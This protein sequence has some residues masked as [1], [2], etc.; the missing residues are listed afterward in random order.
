MSDSLRTSPECQNQ[1]VGLTRSLAWVALGANGLAAACYG[2]ERAFLALGMHVEWAAFL[3]IVA[4][5]TIYFVTNACIQLLR[6]FPNGSGSYQIVSMMLGPR[7]GMFSGCA[8]AVEF[9]LALV[10]SVA[11]GVDILLT[12]LAP[13]ARDYALPIKTTLVLMLTFVNLRGMRE[14][15][16]LLMPITLLF[17]ALH[18]GLVLLGLSMRPPTWVAWPAGA[19]HPAPAGDA[20]A[21]AGTLFL[22]LRA[23]SLGGSTYTSVDA[24]SNNIHL[25]SEPRVDSG[26]STAKQIAWTLCLLVAGMFLLFASW[27]DSTLPG[28]PL[29]GAISVDIARQAGLAP[30]GVDLAHLLVLASQGGILLV[31]GNA[32]FLFGPA[33]LGHM[34]SD[35]WIAH[36]FQRLSDRLVRRNGVLLLSGVAL[37]VLWASHGDVGTL[38]VYFSINAF[39]GLMLTKLSLCRYW[40]NLRDHERHWWRR[41]STIA[42]GTVLTA[43]VLSLTLL[44]K[45]IHGGWVIVAVTAVLVIYCLWIRRHY[46]DVSRKRV[47]MDALF[48]PAVETCASQPVLPLRAEQPIAVFL[49]T[50]HLGA[51]MHQLLWVQRMFPGRFRNAIFIS[52]VEVDAQ[53]LHAESE[54]RARRARVQA[55][56][57]ALERFCG[58]NDIGSAHTI[59]TGPDPVEVLFNLVQQTVAQHTSCVCFASRFILPH[60]NA[61]IESLHN[62]TSTHLQNRLH[63]IS[64]PLIILALPLQ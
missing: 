35:G 38:L 27:H 13:A 45:L 1:S 10:I 51:A 59:A 58:A 17:L 40:W 2:P 63:L 5:V 25:L 41:L 32:I 42:L 11:S 3:A 56:I 19:Q 53:A 43:V 39:A 18:F 34:S 60:T 62:Q 26:R 22:F 8:H 31:A 54:L 44:D 24:V 64:V 46:D 50:E 20:L 36:R 33:L 15:V 52:A 12:L 61:Y 37:V 49:V 9:S 14:S 30:A 23:F 7:I 47:A 29:I 21:F 57:D 28:E 4:I 16:L 48:L 55:T 6:L